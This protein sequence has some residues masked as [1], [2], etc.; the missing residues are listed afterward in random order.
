MPSSEQTLQTHLDATTPLICIQTFEE[1]RVLAYMKAYISA[2]F[3]EHRTKGHL[4]FWSLTEGLQLLSAP[5]GSAEQVDSS[6]RRE[7]QKNNIDLENDPKSGLP[8][9]TRADMMQVLTAA[10]NHLKMGIGA[11][12][13][14]AETD[15][16]HTW[17]FADGTQFLTKGNAYPMQRKLR[18]FYQYAMDSSAT[19]RCIILDPN[20]ESP[21]RMD[22]VMS[23]IRWDL[24]NRE[25]IRRLIDEWKTRLDVD[26]P[27][28]M[29][30]DR[31]I[32][33]L[34]GLSAHEICRVFQLSVAVKGTFTP[35]F[36]LKEKEDIIQK[37]GLL[38]HYS[39]IGGLDKIGGLENLKSWLA[40]RRNAFG[41]RARAFGL[42]I[43]KGVMVAGVAGT[44]KTLVAKCI[45][46]AWGMPVLH[47]DVGSLMNSYLG[48][49]EGRLRKALAVADAMAPC[50]LF[51]DEAEKA[52]GGSGGERDGGTGG[53]LLGTWLTWMNDHE[54]EVFTVM[55]ANRVW[56]LPPEF[57]RAGRFDA[58]FFVD[59]PNL[60]EREAILRVHLQNRNRNADDKTQFPDLSRVANLLEGYTGAEIEGVVNAAMFIAFNSTT[61]LNQ[62]ALI[63]C[64]SSV[65]PLSI[66]MGEEIEKLREWG[67]AR[68][69]TA[70]ASSATEATTSVPPVGTGLK[71][72]F[73]RPGQV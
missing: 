28:G 26:L 30:Y 32:D 34:L 70:S 64:A 13:G 27:I 62:D 1:A 9:C 25:A 15:A 4:W 72:V 71:K 16:V 3:V 19:H 59:L 6:M 11:V 55:T 49:S 68:A 35:E 17:V 65:V 57:L 61:P 43:P 60:K 38:R 24:P 5:L 47:L 52:F 21:D 54:S 53:R 37:S 31:M 23:V 50:V 67:K 58:V 14:A 22:K 41:E 12:D 40:V 2:Q 46:A 10:I 69:I 8:R 29:S 36:A 18:D 44:G 39:S 51:V 33:A 48:E 20:F 42:N 45:G 73:R 63:S 56:S 66:T 7:L